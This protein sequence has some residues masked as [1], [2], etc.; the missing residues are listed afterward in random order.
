M[1]MP[2]FRCNVT[3]VVLRDENS[4]VLALRRSLIV[5]RRTSVPLELLKR[6]SSLHQIRGAGYA[7]AARR[8]AAHGSAASWGAASVAFLAQEREDGRSRGLARTRPRDERWSQ[9]ARSV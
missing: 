3:E 6:L 9:T 7:L 5:I 4:S 1:G 8:P 2:R